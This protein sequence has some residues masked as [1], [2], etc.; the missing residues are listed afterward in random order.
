[1][2]PA[3]Q[4]TKPAHYTLCGVLFHHGESVGGG[5]YTVNAL[6]PNGDGDAGEV[7]LHIDDEAVSLVRDEDVFGK[8]GT[9]S[10]EREADELCAY[11][12][13]Y[14]RTSS[15]GTYWIAFFALLRTLSFVIVGYRIPGPSHHRLSCG[16]ALLM[17]LFIYYPPSFDAQI[18][19]EQLY[20]RAYVTVSARSQDYCEHE[21]SEQPSA[22]G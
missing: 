4:P 10:A 15:K 8:H 18:G 14:C 22:K 7:W 20:R 17:L 1:M 5:H 19:A 9:D 2:V 3:R 12:L 16:K 6:H 21:H 13:F 11:L